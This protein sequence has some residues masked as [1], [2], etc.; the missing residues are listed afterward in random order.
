MERRALRLKR[1]Q[2]AMAT[3][4]DSLSGRNLCIAPPVAP[5][6]QLRIDSWSATF[7]ED[8]TEQRSTAFSPREEDLFH[9]SLVISGAKLRPLSPWAAVGS[10]ALL[11]LLLLALVVIPLFH[12][13]VLPERRT[14]TMLYMPP[15]AAVSNVG[16]RPTPSVSKNTPTKMSIPIRVHTP[17]E[18]LSPPAEP[19]AAVVGGVPG[20]VVGGIPGGVLSGM[21]R[22]N[23]STPVLVSTSAQAPKRIRV[24]APMAEANLVH[25]VAPKYP[26]EAGRE[27]I[28]GTVVLMAVIGK[29]GTVRDVRVESGLP[30]L[31]QAAIDAVKQWRYRPYLLNGEPVEIDSEITINFNLSRG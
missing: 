15:A 26:P 13:D 25:D 20:G 6:P 2:C 19:A 18:I 23:G 14:L 11:S 31:A 7:L 21:V 1:D 30:L 3:Y 12:T 4:N 29:D 24:P 22:S 27:R 5:R 28:E 9:D 16:R 8:G 10:V 17:Q